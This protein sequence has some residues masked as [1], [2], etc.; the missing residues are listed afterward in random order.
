MDRGR[1]LTNLC[2]RYMA[3]MGCVGNL[4]KNGI[5]SDKPLKAEL[6]RSRVRL[7]WG[8]PDGWVGN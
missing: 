4:M 1:Y 6:V 7:P 5:L 3:G 8:I 2:T